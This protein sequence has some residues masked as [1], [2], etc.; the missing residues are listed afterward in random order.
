MNFKITL[1]TNVKIFLLVSSLFIVVFVSAQNQ[2]NSTP[3]FSNSMPGILVDAGGHKLHLNVQGKGS[4]AIIFENGSQDFSFIWSL[5]QPEVAKFA[6]T[7][8]Y[9]R[10]GYA[11][12]EAGPMPRTSKQIC[13][14]LHTALNNAGI[15]PPY[16]LV[17]QSYGGFLVRAFARYYPKE[18][19]GIVLVEAVQEDQKIFMGGD[20]PQ[21]IRDFAKG[22]P[23]PA[24]QTH[25]TA[26]P[27]TS[28]QAAMNT[29][30]DPLFK[31]FPDSIQQMQIWAQSQTQFI[32]AVQGEMDWSPE[33]VANIYTHKNDADYMLGNMP[34][35][36][37][38]RGK[39]GFD[40]RAD[41][42]QLEKERL[43]AQ[44]QLVDLSSNNKH[45]IDMNS[46][47]NI[48]VEDPAIVIKAIKDVFTAC[49]KYMSLQQIK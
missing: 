41:S 15:H 16:I 18:V 42:L 24:V 1:L 11:W 39:G 37:I 45:I 28:Q 5:V 9:D 21:L 19:V 48:H 8:S 35:V 43:Q 13:Y 40:G 6:E 29:D 7:V 46:G 14:E 2:N 27:D 31:K 30:I 49:T 47:H 3:N 38:T 26:Q 36:V 17:G 20:N 4:P 23:L 22:R 12:S 25:F 34:L 10:A 44:E 33:D 32:K